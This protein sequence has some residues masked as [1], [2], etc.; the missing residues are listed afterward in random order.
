MS[1]ISPENS[2]L[3]QCLA[4]TSLLAE[5]SNANFLRSEYFN[6]LK[7]G[8]ES[9]KKILVTSG[10]GNPATMQIMLYALLIVPKELLSKDEYGLLESNISELNPIVYK[11]IE[12]GTYSTYEGENNCRNIDYIRHIRNAVAHSNCKYIS[13]NGKNFVVF[14]DEDNRN[15]KG[16]RNGKGLLKECSIK[17]DCYKIGSF[18][19]KLQEFIMKHYVQT[20][21]KCS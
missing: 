5:L 17:I 12:E 13:E 6:N 4:T 3:L 19:M 14:K 15:R 2:L 9:I 11:I 20:Q 8:N 1:T 21:L 7:F 18:L 10:I 16:K